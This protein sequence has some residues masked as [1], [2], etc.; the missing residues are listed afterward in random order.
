MVAGPDDAAARRRL[1]PARPARAS[2]RRRPSRWPARAD[3]EGALRELFGFAGFRRGQR[4]AV[5]AALAGRDVLVVMPT[6]SGKSL[7]Y[8]LPALMRTDLT[9]V[10]SP[11]VS[12]MQD[13][14]EALARVAPQRVALVN[15]QQDAATN[16]KAV[17]RAVAGQ[18]R[19]L[20][21]APER[22]ASPGFLERVRHAKIG[23]LRRRR[24]P[25]RLAVGAR[26]P[27]GLLP[28]GRRRALARGRRHRRLDGDRDAAG[29]RG[30]RHAAGAARAGR[31][32]RRAS[33]ARTSPSPSCARR[34][35]RR[36]TA[37]SLRRSPS[38]TRCRRSSTPAR[39]RS[40]TG[41]LPRL[42]RELGVT[43]A[44]LPRRPA[45]RRAGAGPA[46]LHVRRGAGRGGDQRVR[47]GRRQGR[48]AHRVPRDACRARSRPTTRRPAAPAATA[49]RPAACCSPR[50]RTRACTSS[51]SSARPCPRTPSPASRGACSAGPT[52]AASTSAS[53]ELG[54]AGGC[55]E[56]Q[57]RAIVGHLAR[58]KVHPARAVPARSRDGPHR[59]G[60]WTG[61]RSPPA[62][63]RPRRARGRAGASTARCGR[64]SR[65]IAAGA[66][67]SCATSATRP[68]PRP[69][70]RAATCAIPDSSPRCRPPPDR[71]GRAG[72]AARRSSPTGRSRP[73]EAGALDEAILDVVASAAARGRP[74]PRG[75]DPA[76]RALAGGA[77][78]L[79][80]RAA[81]L[82]R[83]TGTWRRRPC[84][85]GS[86]PW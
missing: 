55:D 38:P 42:A 52:T 20:Y 81:P 29:G 14:V 34:R 65:A 61:R 48:R 10:V 46:A 33:T 39:A 40:A 60:A 37:A 18:V 68:R 6:G 45:A 13:Q 51:S 78:V 72:A 49:G 70:A 44:Q 7:T 35:R 8:Q 50:A 67:A 69:R 3:P 74:H 17:E 59:R 26:L 15:A 32:S 84:S 36:S 54:A 31:R 62:G 58:A 57:V 19:L 47:H 80:R 27:P 79:L 25:L 30:H 77:Q 21:V 9:V 12:L 16:R 1:R 83:P 23:L 85:S 28:P 73:G 66:R 56:E 75:G 2:R 64:G 22:F 4:E 11:L 24:G 5:D 76:R 63:P 86:T 82:R 41:S 71:R 43:V 53:H